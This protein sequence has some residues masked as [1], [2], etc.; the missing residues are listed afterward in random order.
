MLRAVLRRAEFRATAAPAR[1]SSPSRSGCPRRLPRWCGAGRR[2]GRS[3]Q[4]LEPQ[5]T[6]EVVFGAVM[7]VGDVFHFLGGDGL[8]RRSEALVELLLDGL[9]TGRTYRPAKRKEPV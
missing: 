4:G 3:G 1:P 5:A 2:W 9:A 7:G 6:A 8:E